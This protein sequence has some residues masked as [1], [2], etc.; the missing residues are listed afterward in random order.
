MT[1]RRVDTTPRLLSHVSGRIF[2]AMMFELG[3]DYEYDSFTSG[4]LYAQ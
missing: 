2:H 4:Y 1:G 3:V